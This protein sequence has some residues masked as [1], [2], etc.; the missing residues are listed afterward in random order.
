MLLGDIIARLDDE[1]V[2]MEALVGLG[3]LA[4]LACVEGAAEVEGITAGEFA[5]QA[6]QAFSTGASDEDWVSLI[7]VMGQ[8]SDPGQACLKKMVEFALR[9]AAPTPHACGHHH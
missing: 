5:A 9:P 8:T 6:V 3:D 1:A 2:A 4:L 7:G